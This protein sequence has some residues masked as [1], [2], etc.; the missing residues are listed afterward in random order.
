MGQANRALS[1]EAAEVH[2]LVGTAPPDAALASAKAL[3]E[4]VDAADEAEA[5]WGYVP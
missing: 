3:A 5:R 1:L 2:V 4:A